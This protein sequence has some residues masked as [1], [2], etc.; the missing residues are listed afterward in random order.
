MGKEFRQTAEIVFG[1]E[2]GCGN[3]PHLATPATPEGKSLICQTTNGRHKSQEKE[4]I[5][6]SPV[7]GIKVRT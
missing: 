1:F 3:V 5:W 4:Q 7:D 2:C 6:F